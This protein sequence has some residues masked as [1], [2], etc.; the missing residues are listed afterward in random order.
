MKIRLLT[1]A[2]P[3]VAIALATAAPTKVVTY[4]LP[5]DVEDFTLPPGEGADLAAGN[6][7]GCHSLDYIRTQP[8]GKGAQFWKDEVHKMVAVYGAP[9]EPVDAEMIAKYLAESYGHPVP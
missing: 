2:S 8:R 6:C 9:I 1:L 3:L 5:D 4:A 7:A